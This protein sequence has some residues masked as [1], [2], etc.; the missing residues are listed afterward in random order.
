MTDTLLVIAVVGVLCMACFF[1]GAKVGQKVDKG[2]TIEVP[3]VNPIKAIREREERRN[4]QA[5]QERMNIILQN[6]EHYDG[7]GGNQADVPE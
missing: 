5:E 3:S 7:F 6:I 4:V 1:I 2:E